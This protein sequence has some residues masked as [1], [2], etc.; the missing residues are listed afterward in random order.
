VIWWREG[1]SD[2]AEAQFFLRIGRDHPVLVLGVSGE[3]GLEEPGMG[4]SDPKFLDRTSWDWRK[5]TRLTSDVLNSDVRDVSTAFQRPITLSFRVARDGR[6]FEEE[7]KAFTFVDDR[8]FERHRG[9]AAASDIVN[10]IASLDLQKDRWVVA[11][12]GIDFGPSE[13]DGFSADQIASLLI[14]F[15]PLRRRLRGRQVGKHRFH[16]SRQSLGKVPTRGRRSGSSRRGKAQ[17]D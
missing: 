5:L 3:K 6:L 9:K 12:F 16:S 2:Y 8:W 1:R 13:V 17:D 14:R 10:H 4:P 15:E 7:S 11:S